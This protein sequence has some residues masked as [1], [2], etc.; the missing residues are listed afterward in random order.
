[1]FKASASVKEVQGICL[2]RT[3][4]QSFCMRTAALAFIEH[5]SY[6]RKATNSFLEAS[7]QLCGLLLTTATDLRTLPV[8]LN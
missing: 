4:L 5:I 7:L 2:E 6:A 8:Y 1:M 3:L